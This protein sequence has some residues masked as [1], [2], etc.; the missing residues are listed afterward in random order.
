VTKDNNEAEAVEDAEIIVAD[1]EPAGELVL[2]SPDKLAQVIA[3]MTEI[4][5]SEAIAQTK[6]RIVAEM[7]AAETEDELWTELPTWSSKNNVGRT[8][9]ITDVR[10]VFQ[11]RYADA[12]T[13][14]AGGFLA[15]SAV[16][17]DGANGSPDPETGEITASSEP[18]TVG[19]LSTSALRLAGRIGWY[20]QHGKLPVKLMVVKRGE[21]ARG[22]PI[23]DAEK[24]D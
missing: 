8:F 5:T 17:V 20:H 22:F 12:E 19:I 2:V 16:A 9:E 6:Y 13:G 18:G 3:G 24:L 1:D 7:L 15:C 23:L 10:G 21:N 14:L 11:S 4:D